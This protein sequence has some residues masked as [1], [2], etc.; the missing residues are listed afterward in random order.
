MFDRIAGIYDLGNHLLSLGQDFSWRKKLSLALKEFQPGV[1]LDLAAGTADLAIALKRQIP[2]SEIIALDLAQKMLL[3][4]AEKINRKKLQNSVF[5]AG[6]DIE[7]M[8]FPDQSFDALTIG[9][10]IR[11]LESRAKGLA[12][13][14]RI[15]KPGGAFAILEFS[16]PESGVFAHLYHTYLNILL[17]RI[18]KILRGQNAY[19][20]LRDTIQEFPAPSQFSQELNQAGFLSINITPLSRGIV[21]LYLALKPK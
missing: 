2:D 11:N 10:G 18:G 13:I 4:A 7:Q 9:F 15:L 21:T 19:F 3:R 12:E 5:L 8:P 14:F 16:L 1:I 17:P 6:A 20:Y